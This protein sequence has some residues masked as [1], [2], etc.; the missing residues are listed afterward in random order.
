MDKF[1]VRLRSAQP[2]AKSYQLDSCHALRAGRRGSR[3]SNAGL[4]FEHI[5]QKQSEARGSWR[6]VHAHI[7][8]PC[9]FEAQGGQTVACSRLADSI[10]NSTPGVVT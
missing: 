2:Y 4:M 6:T 10:S 8:I 3:A 9:S 1:P 7:G 5:Q